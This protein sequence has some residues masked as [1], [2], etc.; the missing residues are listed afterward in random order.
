M[1]ILIGILIALGVIILAF[2]VIVALQP[3]DF[4]IRRTASISAP[5]P[6]VFAQVNDF[7][8]W[9]GWSPWAKMDPTC[10]N[11]FEGAPAGT[12]AGFSWLGNSK[13]GQ[14]RMTITESKPSDL[15]RIDLAFVKPFVANNIAEFTFKP[16]GDQTVV[17]WDMTG[18]RNFFFKAMCMFMNMDKMVGG[19]FEKGLADMKTIAEAGPKL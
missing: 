18:K 13:V 12:G 3:S 1:P 11:T 16:Q 14:G 9:E 19:E 17:Q 8:K 10:I 15:I 5:P 7:H 2:V 4:R 6:V